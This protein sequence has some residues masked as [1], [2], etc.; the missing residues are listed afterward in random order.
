MSSL[1]ESFIRV[2]AVPYLSDHHVA[3][4]GALSVGLGGL[5]DVWANLGDDGCSKG[6]VGDKV[7]VHNVDVQP[8]CSM[9]DGVRASLA[10]RAKVGAQD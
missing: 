2:P 3:V 5:L 6:D 9:A 1:K 8:V 7:A 4:E 10:E